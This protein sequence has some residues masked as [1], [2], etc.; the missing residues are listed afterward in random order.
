M[1]TIGRKKQYHKGGTQIIDSWTFRCRQDNSESPKVLLLATH[2]DNVSC[3]IRGCYLCAI[4]KPSNRKLG[5]YTPL[6]V[7]SH[8]WE[9]ISMDFVGGHPMS[10]KGHDYKYVVIDRFI[11]LC[12][13]M[14]CK[15]Q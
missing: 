13:W 1:Y 7:P 12:I 14:P 9:S 4:S 3:F 15:K 5:L 10:R 2:D 11:K 6:P 8:P